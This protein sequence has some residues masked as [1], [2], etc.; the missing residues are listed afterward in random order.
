MLGTLGVESRGFAWSY[1]PGFLLLILN[2]RGEPHWNEQ[3]ADC[4]LRSIGA[5]KNVLFFFID[6]KC[7]PIYFIDDL[8][9]KP[10]TWV[11]RWPKPVLIRKKIY[12]NYIFTGLV[13][14]I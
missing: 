12:K 1:K 13:N 8:E 10:K 7:V 14:S 5:R 6:L 9:N 4:G 3:Y 2:V 11:N